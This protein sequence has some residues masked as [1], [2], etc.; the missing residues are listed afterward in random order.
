MKP[1]DQTR[2][3]DPDNQE[4]PGDCFAACMASILEKQIQDVPDQMVH[5]SPGGDPQHSWTL[6]MI[7]VQRYLAVA[8]LQ[9]IE[10]DAKTIRLDEFHPCYGILSGPSPRDAD[11]LHAVVGF[12]GDIVHDPHPSREG[13]PEVAY[14]GFFASFCAGPR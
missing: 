4:P 6:H 7:D 3:F 9:Y 1:V 8:G 12:G 10:V 2:F 14:W 5:W 13:I 11:I